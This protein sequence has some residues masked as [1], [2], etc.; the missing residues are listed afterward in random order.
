[1]PI[2]ET[3]NVILKQT[4]KPGSELLLQC[5]GISVSIEFQL[6]TGPITTRKQLQSF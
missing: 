2:T 5:K 3:K 1:M 4:T 6:H